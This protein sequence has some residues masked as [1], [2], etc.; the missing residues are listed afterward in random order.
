MI[1]K[2]KVSVLLDNEKIPF[3]VFEPPVKLVLDTTKIPDGKH[4]LKNQRHFVKWNSKCKD[5]SF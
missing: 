1:N 5:H 2:R 4:E 3:G